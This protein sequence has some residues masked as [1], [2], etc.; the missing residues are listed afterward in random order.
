MKNNKQIL[1]TA[2]AVGLGL[3]MA[4]LVSC[5]P[6]KDQNGTKPNK[7]V[8]TYT[9]SKLKRADTYE[10]ASD[11]VRGITS[12]GNGDFVYV[13]GEDQASLKSYDV[14]KD[15][16]ADAL[17]DWK[18]IPRAS[19]H[20]NSDDLSGRRVG[21]YIGTQ[22]TKD[23]LMF[24]LTNN[25]GL[26]VLKGSGQPNSSHYAQNTGNFL[27]GKH[28]PFLAKNAGGDG[29]IYLLRLDGLAEKSV[30]FRKFVSPPTDDTVSV[31]DDS[32][33]EKSGIGLTNHYRARAQDH[34]NN[35][36]LADDKG[37]VVRIKAADVGVADKFLDNNG[38]PIYKADSFKLDGQTKNDSIN[39]MA[40]VDGKV[41]VLGLKSTNANNGGL[42][43]ADITEPNIK[44]L[45]FGK[46]LGLTV[47]SIA[48]ERI[49][50]QDRTRISALIT[51]DK[52]FLMLGE[53]AQVM[54]MVAGKGEL[55]NI[56]HLNDVR[57]E[58]KDY[59]K[60][61]SG[62]SGLKLP[63]IDNGRAIT[64][65][66]KGAAQDK[67]GMWYLAIVGPAAD[68]GGIIKLDIR[69]DQVELE[70]PIEVPLP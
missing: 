53:K 22:A 25:D 55:I 46:G 27:N 23:G 49:P 14:E 21:A 56:D 40:L 15:K 68:D 43:M 30:L 54:E 6:P 28:V 51:T 8:T 63:K 9:L 12:S 69:T 60:A 1:S 59:E 24:M 7:T 38:K 20:I 67:N 58:T 37:N 32:L 33:K 47:D 62:F 36:L 65:K 5:I 2:I 44:W 66:Y 11:K 17:G 4:G 64:Y 29:F 50:H 39:T 42:A 35:L 48:T 31:W 57:A 13:I 34:Q 3:L 26:V 45:H 70:R 16:W 61:Q 52:G 41:L 18:N 19:P 10:L